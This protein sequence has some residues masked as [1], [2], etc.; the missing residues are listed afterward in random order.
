MVTPV[1]LHRDTFNAV[2]RLM[3]RRP[4]TPEQYGAMS[5]LTYKYNVLCIKEE[6]DYK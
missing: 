5:L 4:K 3:R 6:R 1:I 2:R